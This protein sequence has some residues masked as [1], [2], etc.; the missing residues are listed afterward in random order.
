MKK[1]KRF[2][3]RVPLKFKYLLLFAVCNLGASVVY[4]CLKAY[5][6]AQRGYTGAFG[7]ETAVWFIGILFVL[8]ADT[9]RIGRDKDETQKDR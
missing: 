2:M 5:A 1:V 7:G 6:E 3:E 9:I 8:I 4:P